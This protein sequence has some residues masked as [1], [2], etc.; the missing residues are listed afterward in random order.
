MSVLPAVADAGVQCFTHLRP[1]VSTR[2]LFSRALQAD[3]SHFEPMQD[4]QLAVGSKPLL[5]SL[6]RLTTEFNGR[7]YC[8]T[9]APAVA[10]IK[11]ITV[12]SQ[13]IAASRR[14]CQISNEQHHKSFTM[15]TVV[16]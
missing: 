14:L 16:Q 1:S 6:K 11:G 8:Q 5:G 4:R 7:T 10:F 3:S 9:L 2:V 13:D 15:H 12:L